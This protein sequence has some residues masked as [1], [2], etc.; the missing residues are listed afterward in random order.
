M[1][2]TSESDMQ[3]PIRRIQKPTQSKWQAHSRAAKA[4]NKHRFPSS[5]SPITTQSLPHLPGY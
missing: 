1:F 2:E 5:V 3:V 4:A